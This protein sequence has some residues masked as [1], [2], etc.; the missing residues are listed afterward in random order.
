MEDNKPDFK[1]ISMAFSERYWKTDDR[2]ISELLPE[3]LES[4]WKA[5][6]LPL[7]KEKEE[8]K[9]ENAELREALREIKNKTKYEANHDSILYNYKEVHE[10]ATSLLEKHES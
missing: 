5:Y 1:T 6:V 10:L 3:T 8:L 7:Q 9:K 4:F 2:T